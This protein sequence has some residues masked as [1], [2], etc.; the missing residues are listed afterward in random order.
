MI[1]TTTMMTEVWPELRHRRI[2]KI[3]RIRALEVNNKIIAIICKICCFYNLVMSA[4]E[5]IIQC[6]KWTEMALKFK[7]NRAE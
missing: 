4:K 2:S 6:K 5:T 3:D 1:M 7:V